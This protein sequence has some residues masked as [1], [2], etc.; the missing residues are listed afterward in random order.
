ME[1]RVEEHS[2][3]INDDLNLLSFKCGFGTQRYRFEKGSIATATQ[4]MSENSDMYR[5]LQKHELVL[6]DVIKELILII[7]R[8]GIAAG[9][10]GLTE[11]VELSI[12]FDDSI[13]EDKQAK[14]NEDRKDVSMGAMS[15]VEYRVRNYGE[16]EEEAAKKIPEQNTV[17]E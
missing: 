1:L 2:Q 10:T 9:V 7:V 14:R 4:V 17:M 12:D 6:D 8:L 15:L 13:I 3:A 11:D 5:S 16:T